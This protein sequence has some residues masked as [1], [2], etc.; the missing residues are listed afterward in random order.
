MWKYG[1]HYPGRSGPYS[2]FS[3]ALDTIKNR[4]YFDT[5]NSKYLQPDLILTKK[6][7]NEFYS[8]LEKN[9][10]YLI[11]LINTSITLVELRY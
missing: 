1:A 8:K 2:I 3:K 5:N 11:L 6:Y 7:N 4:K 10:T 9:S